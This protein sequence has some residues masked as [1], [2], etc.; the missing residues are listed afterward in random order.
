MSAVQPRKNIVTSSFFSK[1]NPDNYEVPGFLQ[2]FPNS[3][4]YIKVVIEL[5][6]TCSI[7]KQYPLVQTNIG[8]HDAPQ[9]KSS[10]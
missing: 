1:L 9:V 7:F 10:D 2:E 3:K 8:H 6:I 5:N 4:L